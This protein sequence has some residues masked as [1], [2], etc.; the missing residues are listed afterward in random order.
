MDQI[1]PVLG[2]SLTSSFYQGGNHFPEKEWTSELEA[3]VDRMGQGF[4]AEWAGFSSCLC[5]FL[6]HTA[7]DRSSSSAEH[8]FLVSLPC[9]LRNVIG[10]IQAKHR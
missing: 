3:A 8:P 2:E 1:H 9:C 5:Q 10:G 6:A 4:G 7:L